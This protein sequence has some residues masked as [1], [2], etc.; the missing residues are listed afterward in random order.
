MNFNIYNNYNK[1]Y[2]LNAIENNAVY[3]KK[4]KLNHLL[5]VYYLVLQKDYLEEKNI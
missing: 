3:I 4:L 1:K 2:K 5:R